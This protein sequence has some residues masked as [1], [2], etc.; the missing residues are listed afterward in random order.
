MVFSED[1]LDGTMLSKSLTVPK[2]PNRPSSRAKAC[3]RVP[4][5]L[6][7]P[8]LEP[9]TVLPGAG[10]GAG[11][12]SGWGVGATGGGVGAGAPPAMA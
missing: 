6:D 9:K 5:E 2:E 3:S 7:C 10:V 12:G 8:K 11:D 4:P 1:Q